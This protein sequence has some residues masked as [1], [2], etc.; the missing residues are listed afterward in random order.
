MKSFV[1]LALLLLA[2]QFSKAQ[3]TII[4][5]GVYPNPFA[6]ILHI[7]VTLTQSDTATFE[8][9]DVLG[10]NVATISNDTLLSPGLNSIEYDG[11]AL[12]DGVYLL[13]M[14]FTDEIITAH[15][16]KQ[17]QSTFGHQ[18]VSSEL[19]LVYPN[20]T[21][22]VV[23]IP[24]NGV[25]TISIVNSNGW[26]ETF[27]TTESQITTSHLHQGVYVVTVTDRNNRLVL[28]QRIIKTN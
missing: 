10:Q 4:S 27:E 20:P 5:L 18:S 6:T 13:K 17:G 14:A 12:A 1:C 3:S 22:D 11:S 23:S 25:R 21:S 24:G 19:V 8:L 9:F 16:V 2:T 28:T 26:I 15:L 7:E